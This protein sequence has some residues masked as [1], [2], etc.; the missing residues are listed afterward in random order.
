VAGGQQ[1]LGR[2]QQISIDSCCCCCC[3]TCGPTVRRSN[4][5]YISGFGVWDLCCCGLTN[6][7][8]NWEQST[9]VKKRSN[10]NFKNAKRR[11]K[12]DKNLKKR[13]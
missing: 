5:L 11:I 7:V 10:K 9:G 2:G 13:L 1:Q 6:V 4:I 3:A 8:W 12:R